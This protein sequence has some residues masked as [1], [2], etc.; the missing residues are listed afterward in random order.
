MTALYMFRAIFMTFFGEYRG[1]AAPEPGH[2]GHGTD[3]V[4]ATDAGHEPATQTADAHGAAEGHGGGHGWLAHPHESPRSMVLPLVLLAIPAIA[5]GWL[6]PSSFFGE[7]VEGALL[8]E[9]RHFHFHA[10]IVVVTA[11][12]LAA[13]AGIGVAA[14]IYFAQRP[15]SEDIRSRMGPLPRITERLY[16]VNEF[17]EG[18]VVRLALFG[19][20]ARAA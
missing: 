6:A 14:A 7:F 1:G 17:A 15:R 9:M 8:P 16:Y 18:F 4:H 20:I 5:A 19:G 3:D 13:L 12:T 2:G 11:S 10:D